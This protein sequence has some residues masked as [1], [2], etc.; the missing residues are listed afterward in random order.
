MID[1][2]II[3]DFH[4]DEFTQMFK[5]YFAELGISVRDWNGLFDEMSD[6]KNKAYLCFVD[7]EAAGFL[8]FTEI[9]FE[10]WF[11]SAKYGFIRE[12]WLKKSERGRG[13]GTELLAK[14]EDYFI[15]EGLSAS[16]LTTN[17]AEGFYRKHGYE[18]RADIS[19]KNG[20]RVFVK[21]L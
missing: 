19:A 6:G 12:F 17:T 9:D 4:G 3:T 5:Q 16:I 1:Y 21:R 14:A 8:M 20:D 7:G 2:Q 15:S 13:L 11:F 18:H 10:S